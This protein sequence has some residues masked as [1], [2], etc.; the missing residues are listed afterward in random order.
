[1]LE[2]SFHETL[3]WKRKKLSITQTSLAQEMGIS[4]PRLSEIER[5]L[6]R[7]TDLEF[8]ALVQRLHLGFGQGLT[9]RPARFIRDLADRGR[10]LLPSPEPYFPKPDRTPR[11]RFLA[12]HRKHSDLV[13]ELRSVI[14]QRDDYREL[15][16]FCNQLALD[17]A[18]EALYVL[19][20]LTLGAQP[21]LVSP[22]SLG[23]LPW[24]VVC[25]E[26]KETITDRLF[27]CLALEGVFEFFQLT[28]ATPRTYRV[29]VLTYEQGWSC[30]EIDGAGHSSEEDAE[31]T[32]AL[33]MPVRRLSG[34]QVLQLASPSHLRRSA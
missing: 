18:D 15:N 1:M 12:L 32:V 11:V 27:P 16:F 5:G 21:C 20:R 7:P 34:N 4:Q 33:G 31:K 29:D 10:T 22:Q 24:P 8:V 17:S 30:L 2:K 13:T 6:V 3:R 23:P 9:V 26:S 25:P 19:H 28:F 14:K